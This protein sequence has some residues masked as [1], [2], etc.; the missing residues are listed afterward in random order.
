MPG[1]N[2]PSKSKTRGK[3]APK[4][5]DA[6]SPTNSIEHAEPEKAV[7]VIEALAADP[8]VVITRLAE[9]V[10]LP[11]PT[12]SALVE[13]LRTKYAPAVEAVRQGPMD[14]VRDAFRE[15]AERALTLIMEKGKLEKA[16]PKDLALIAAIAVD[17]HQLLSGEPTQIVSFQGRVELEEAKNA[18]MKE[19]VRRGMLS[20][21]VVDVP[22]EDVS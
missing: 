21:P 18:L 4:G 12:V 1:R 15:T 3:R 16:S 8:E 14:G 17:K 2:R 13:R 20:S 9:Q 19:A 6:G 7:D 10:G 22:Y 11:A 5:L